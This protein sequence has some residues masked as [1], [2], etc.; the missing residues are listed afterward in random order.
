MLRIKAAALLL[1]GTER[2]AHRN[3]GQLA[4]LS[5][6]EGARHIH[7]RRQLNSIAVMESDLAVVHKFRFREGLVPFPGKIQSTHILFCVCFAGKQR[8]SRYGNCNEI[9]DG[10]IVFLQR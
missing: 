9:F 10:H 1:Y 6:S 3:R 2:T 4:T 7:I 5:A 8:Q